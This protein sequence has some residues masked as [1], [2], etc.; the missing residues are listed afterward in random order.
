MIKRG[1]IY[2]VNFGKKYNSEFGKIR[3]ALIV[4]NDVAN[5]NIDK[6]AFKGVSVIPLTTHLC[7]GNVRVR[8][9]QRDH[10]EATSEICI[11]ELCTLDI[12]RI[13]FDQRL[14]KLTSQEQQEVDLKLSQHL[15]LIQG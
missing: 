10:L 14:T 11:N 6:V 1:D 9:D 15:G 13:D 5:R 8:I 7:G 3:P 12:S 2:L 4:Q